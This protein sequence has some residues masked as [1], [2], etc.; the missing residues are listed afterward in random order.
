M[1]RTPNRNQDLRSRTSNAIIIMSFERQS[2]AFL[3]INNE[4]INISCGYM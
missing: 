4:N 1:H 3:L 2:W